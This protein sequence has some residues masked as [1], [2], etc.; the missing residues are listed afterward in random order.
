MADATLIQGARQLAEAQSGVNMG[1]AFGAGYDKAMARNQAEMNRM[2][3]QQQAAEKRAKDILKEGDKYMR[4]YVVKGVN[5][6]IKG[7]TGG[8]T[9]EDMQHATEY[10]TAQKSTLSEG[11]TLL[12]KGYSVSDPEAIKKA[13]FMGEEAES[14][15]VSFHNQLSLLQGA[16]KEYAA[17]KNSGNLAAVEGNIKNI[18]NANRLMTSNWSVK[19]GEIVFDDGTRLVDIS[20]PYT[21]DIGKGFME[22]AGSET[23]KVSKMTTTELNKAT[24][25][26]ENIRSTAEGYFSGEEGIDRLEVLLSQQYFKSLNTGFANIVLDRE[27]PQVAIDQAVD[28]TVNAIYGVAKKDSPAGSAAQTNVVR[29]QLAATVSEMQA[30]EKEILS[31]GPSARPPADIT[32]TF[33]FGDK[34]NPDQIKVKWD[35]KENKW[36]YLNSKSMEKALYNTLEDLMVAN[37]TIFYK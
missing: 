21:T 13:R 29:P 11:K 9:T 2:L 32:E 31:A 24:T 35:T 17:L 8:L 30:L 20:L 15:A 12:E 3:K 18:E 14:N 10:L 27:N 34:N 4:E 25:K 23:D 22:W 1:A 28:A 7:E 5:S 37:P 6:V 19:E 36:K 33:K 16:R 26:K